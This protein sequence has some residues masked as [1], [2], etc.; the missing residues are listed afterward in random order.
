VK[1]DLNLLR[2]ILLA[3]ESHPNGPWSDAK[4]L[5]DH[6]REQVDYHIGLLD[7]A[8][9]V[10]ATNGDPGWAIFGLTW[11][12]HEFLDLARDPVRWD[13]TL[14]Y[15]THR[16]GGTNFSIIREILHRKASARVTSNDF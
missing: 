14:S 4:M 9:L 5:G 16:A 2:K 3:V 8:G 6:P 7:S 13:A 11:S 12:G 15:A 1:R 10:D